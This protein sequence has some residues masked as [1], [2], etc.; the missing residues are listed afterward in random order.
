VFLIKGRCGVSKTTKKSSDQGSTS[1][2][3]YIYATEIFWHVNEAKLSDYS[4]FTD[5]SATECLII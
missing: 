5:Y 3:M 2:A 1:K 4:S